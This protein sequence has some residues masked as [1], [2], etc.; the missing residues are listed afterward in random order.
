MADGYYDLYP[1]QVISNEPS[2]FTSD[3]IPTYF[4]V[5]I[6]SKKISKKKSAE[7]QQKLNI[8]ELR[9]YLEEKKIKLFIARSDLLIDKLRKLSYKNEQI[10]D[11]RIFYISDTKVR[12][13][14]DANGVSTFANNSE[15][16]K[17]LPGTISFGKKLI[18]KDFKID[19]SNLGLNPQTVSFKWNV[20]DV[21]ILDSLQ[22]DDDEF[23]NYKIELQLANINNDSS[24]YDIYSNVFS[25]RNVEEF[26][27]NDEFKDIMILKPFALLNYSKK[28]K[29]LSVRKRHV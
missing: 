12:P 27:E 24:V 29:K 5:N 22:S 9:K 26:F 19:N 13:R 15:S 1:L 2:R 10:G 21:S 25:E 18:L 7:E 3:T 14:R 23:G 8:L 11:Y 28:F 6:G 16:K 4:P 20:A 17:I